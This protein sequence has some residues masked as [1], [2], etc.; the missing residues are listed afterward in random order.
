MNS[1]IFRKYIIEKLST[2]RVRF[3]FFYRKLISFLTSKIEQK[4][5]ILLSSL[6]V[7]LLSGFAAVV[8]K[9]V[10]HFVQ[11]RS[12]S[13]INYLNLPVLSFILPLIGILLSLLIIVVIF[14]NKFTNG[15]SNIIYLIIRKKAD[16][17]GRKVFSHLLTSG[18]TIGTGGSAGLEAP[19]VVIGAS[20]GSNVAKE[21][22]LNFHHRTLLLACGSAAGISAIFNSPIAGV[23]F[24]FEVL[25]PDITISSFIALLIS[26][27]SSSVLSKLIY[28]GQPFYLVSA[29]W[30]FTALPYYILLGIICGII[31]FYMIR[32]TFRVESILKKFNN[33]IIRAV[34][35]GI[36]L[37]LL[38]FLFPPLFGE[39][40]S[41]IGL[42]LSE[43]HQEIFSSSYLNSILNPELALIMFI[44]L[45]IVFKVIAMALTI[46]SGGNG[47][48]IAPSLFTGAFTGFFIVQ[49]MKLL[50]IIDLNQANFIVVGMAGILSGVLHAPLTAIFLIAEITGGYVLMIPLMI[51]TA[52]SFFI[53]KYFN[54]YSVYTT[55]LARKGIDFRS[56]KEKF[57][58]QHINIESL[59]ETDFD[60][61]HPN[62][63][64]RELVEKI[65]YTRRNLFPVVNDDDK[66]VGVVTLDDIRSVILDKDQYDVV[67]I[68]EIMNSN[69]QTIEVDADINTAVKI[70]EEKQVWNI[71]VTKENKYVGFISKSNLYNR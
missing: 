28:S 26:S 69:F 44:L 15:L 10:V 42:L 19:I 58:L 5:F 30:E 17:P 41:S 34:V 66:L 23:I 45:I 7:G 40:Y 21:F 52:I 35:G 36:F 18:V 11:I 2:I 62:M 25:L 50:G 12:D 38:I 53:S 31:S 49:L 22:K 13:I 9:S 64:L 32:S 39:G 67:L 57:A 4:T 37:C 24:A 8:L 29:G 33:K 27:A 61:I 43:N 47:G 65:Q 14:K 6:F 63:N 68:Y 20:L 60:R 46:G 16:I 70:F 56:E 55:D 48:I 71:A 54:K 51:V 1:K 59:V 3:L